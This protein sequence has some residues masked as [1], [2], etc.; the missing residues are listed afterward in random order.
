MSFAAR[1]NHTGIWRLFWLDNC[2]VAPCR[3]DGAPDI[4][5]DAIQALDVALKH[6]TLLNPLCTAVNRAFF[7]PDPDTIQSLGGGAEVLLLL[8]SPSQIYL[9]SLCFTEVRA[10]DS[11]T[12]TNCCAAGAIPHSRSFSLE[13]LLLSA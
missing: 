13:N 5:Q 3:G 2:S 4:P 7:F 6:G 10:V 12:F 11:H 1:K 9:E 8:L